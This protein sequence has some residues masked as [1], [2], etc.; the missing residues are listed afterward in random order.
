MS[1][2]TKKD[3]VREDIYRIEE[4]VC[5]EWNRGCVYQSWRL[6]PQN[7]VIPMYKQYAKYGRTDEKSLDLCIEILKENTIKITMNTEIQYGKNPHF[8]GYDE[9]DEIPERDW[10]RWYRFVSD[11]SYNPYIRNSGE[12]KGNA[13]YS[14][15]CMSLWKLGSGLWKAQTMDEKMMAVDKVI[16]FIHGLGRMSRWFVSGGSAT[17]NMIA[18]WHAKGIVVSGR[19]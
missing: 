3:P 6:I 4:G 15:A 11:R 7:I 16:N 9:Y 19:Y 2:C 14:D 17:L 8:F 13:R 10:E 12:V 18:E 5:D 1:T